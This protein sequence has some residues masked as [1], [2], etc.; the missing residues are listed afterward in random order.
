MTGKAFD[1][2]DGIFFFF[3][4]FGENPLGVIWIAVCQALLVAALGALAITL[5]GPFYLGLF[6]LVAQEAGGT[7][8]ESQME[9]EVLTLLGPFLASMPLIALL[10][11]VSTLM[12]QAAWLR[13]L[14]RGE[15]A[16]VIPFRLGGD[17]LRLL[18]VNLLYIVVGIAAYLGIAMAAGLVALVAAGVFAGSDG[19][20]AG[21]MATG[22]IVFLGVLTISIIVIVFCIRLASAP[23]L[24]MV[25]RRIRFFESWTASKG[26]F[27]HMALSYL[28]VIGLILVLSTILGTVI[29]LVFL[30]ALLPVIMEFAQ[31]AE[32]HSDV[33]PDEVIAM[34]QGMLNNPGVMVGLATGLV[35]GYAMQIMF[36]GMWHGVGAYNAVRYR[37]GGDVEETDSPTLTADHPAGASPSEG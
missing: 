37:A 18:G 11:I 22:L 17:E 27:W 33:S 34:L 19:S 12:F 6:D 31:M 25:D 9:R 13:F 14:T 16:A 7:L 5:L 3:K 35:L 4:R 36:E 26:V 8:S 10:G 15:I 2:G 20:M 24:T 28:V 32:G 23:A 30:G 29:Q 21:G 1:I